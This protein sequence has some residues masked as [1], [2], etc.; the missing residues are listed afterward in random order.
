MQIS[1]DNVKEF[2]KVQHFDD[3]NLIQMFIDGAISYCETYLNRPILEKN[4]NDTTKWQ[5]PDS[6]YIA[7]LLLVGTWY[8][9]RTNDITATITKEMEYS[10]RSIL[11]PHRIRSL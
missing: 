3:D 11:N 4:M 9:N 1:L 5:V 10:T 8:E 7:I 2:L 6:I